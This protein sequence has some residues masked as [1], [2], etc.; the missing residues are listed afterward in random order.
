MNYKQALKEVYP[1]DGEKLYQQ[2][3]KAKQEQDNRIKRRKIEAK[4]RQLN[5]GKGV[6]KDAR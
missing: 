5:S 2:Y 3:E 6:I 1:F 4:I